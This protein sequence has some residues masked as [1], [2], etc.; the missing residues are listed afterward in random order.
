MRVAKGT[1]AT[2]VVVAAVVG[3]VAGAAGLAV[4]AARTPEGL[5]AA[6][7]P[8]SFP[9][10][11]G[12]F[13]D[14]RQVTVEPTAGGAATVAAGRGGTL[15]AS[16]CRPG[17][18]VA[19]GTAPWSVD[20]APILALAT[21]EPLYRD[22][23]IGS[24]GSDVEALQL[25]LVRLD[26]QVGVDGRFGSQTGRAVSA[27]RVANGL[28]K[29]T[30]LPLAD[31][32]WLPAASATIA[33]CASLGSKIS[34][35]GALGQVGATLVAARVSPLP[36]DLVA[37]A[38]TL[39]VGDVTVPVDEKAAI[40]QGDLAALSA[41]PETGVA[42]ET[43]GQASPVGLHGILALA[44]PLR[45]ATVPASAVI[46]DGSATCV[47]AGGSTTVVRV[48]SSQLGQSVVFFGQATP[49]SVVDVTPDASLTC[50]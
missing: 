46:T 26:Y 11:L 14:A 41:L 8:T 6:S 49:P 13:D 1:W 32:V 37:G 36:A 5:G 17:S 20:G 24:H 31:V 39:T 28:I 48:V 30:G 23:G 47:A 18:A 19:S 27:L 12:S 10:V 21:S 3:V 4:G 38:R 35:G 42:L 15:T 44:D 40:G 9:I 22:L 2:G 43:L 16:S 29:G 7:A 25:E 50:G 34:P 33:E 45:T